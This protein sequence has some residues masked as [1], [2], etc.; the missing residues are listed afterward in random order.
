MLE[1]I[2]VAERLEG[3]TCPIRAIRVADGLEPGGLLFDPEDEGDPL[4]IMVENRLAARARCANALR[5][6]TDR[7]ADAGAPAEI[8]RDARRAGALADGRRVARRCWSAPRAATRRSA[9]P[10]TSDRAWRYDHVAIVAPCPRAPTKSSPT[11][12]SIPRA[13]RDPADAAGEDGRPLGDRLVGARRDAPAMLGLPDA[14]WRTRSRKRM[15]GFL[16]AVALAGPRWN[17]PLG[18]HHAAQITAERLALVG[19]AAHGIHP[20]AGQ[21]L[22]L[23]FRDAAALAEVLVEGARLGLDLG[24]AQLLDRYERWRSLDT[25]MVAMAT[26]A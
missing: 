21:G 15:G 18:F 22:N 4:G 1:T 19:D 16:G 6:G 5:G 11:R 14:R 10:R 7:P 25:F 23:G 3:R 9:R 24:D 8:V 12:S 13:V 17:Y 2:G 20:I 26:D